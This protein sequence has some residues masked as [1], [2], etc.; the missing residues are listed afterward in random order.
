MR[1]ET[2]VVLFFVWFNA[3]AE[4]LGAVGFADALGMPFQTGVGEFGGAVNSL[5]EVNITG[6]FFD[7]LL[8]VF[9]AVTVAFRSFALAL[10]SGPRFLLNLGVPM[11]F[12]VFLSAP[13]ALLVGRGIIY[14]ISGREL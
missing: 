4:M 3:A 1:I 2:S 11:P 7:T 14:M 10:T 8:N 6:G 13:I 9:I 5:G 12:V